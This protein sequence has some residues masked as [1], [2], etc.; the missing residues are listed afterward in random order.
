MAFSSFSS[1]YSPFDYSSLK[2]G[3]GAPAA[4]AGSG[5]GTFNLS[6][7]PQSGSGAYGAVPGQLGLPNPAGDLAAQIPGLAGLNS[8]VA[9]SI[10]DASH[11]ILP[12]DVQKQIQDSSAQFGVSNGMPGSS[13]IAGTLASNRGLRDIGRTSLDQQHWGASAYPGF[14]GAVSGTQTVPAALQADIANTNAINRAAPN[15]TAAASA[16]KQAFDQYLSRLASTSRSPAGGTGIFGGSGFQG[17]PAGGTVP[18]PTPTPGAGIPGVNPGQWNT[19]NTDPTFAGVPGFDY[20]M[21]PGSQPWNQTP[22]S[23]LPWDDNFLSNFN[24]DQ[25]QSSFNGTGALAPQDWTTDPS[26]S[27][28]PYGWNPGGW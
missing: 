1:G 17:G 14:V 11:G 16:A 18:S 8:G 10:A 2:F 9:S 25:P 3:A 28:S 27:D 22:A 6:P 23:G 5:G 4:T 19:L 13:G 20:S 7:A 26:L 12:Q 21:A 24:P 15:P